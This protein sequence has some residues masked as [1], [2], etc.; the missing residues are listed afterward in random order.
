MPELWSAGVAIPEVLLR[1]AYVILGI[2]VLGFV[3]LEA[4]YL[5][6]LA[7]FVTRWKA[8][9]RR[10]RRPRAATQESSGEQEQTYT[11][12]L[13]RYAVATPR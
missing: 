8:D 6:A 3:L 5:V 7:V 10:P 1:Q 12:R 4:A 9:S 11:S 2:F 13:H